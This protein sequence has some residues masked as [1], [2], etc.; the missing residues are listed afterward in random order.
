MNPKSPK[1]KCSD[2][3]TFDSLPKKGIKLYSRRFVAWSLHSV[4]D[5]LEV[6]G[7]EREREG[8]GLRICEEHNNCSKSGSGGSST[9]DIT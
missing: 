1:M 6:G 7:K 5:W 8:G 4:T 3:C 9:V 2:S